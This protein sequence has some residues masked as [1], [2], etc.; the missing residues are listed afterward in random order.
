MIKKYI[1]TLLVLFLFP[2]S[3]VLAMTASSGENVF[4]GGMPIEGN[5]FL[6]GNSVTIDNEVKG[7]AFAFGEKIYVNGK[8]DG[9]LICAAKEVIVNGEVNGNIRCAFQTLKVNGKVE[10][11]V[12]GLGEDMA[13]E[14]N[15]SVGRDLMFAGESADVD[16]VVNGSMDVASSVLNINGNVKQNVNFYSEEKDSKTTGLFVNSGSSINGNV[17][18]NAFGEIKG[19]GSGSILGATNKYTPKIENKDI[20]SDI[21]SQ[22]GFIVALILTTLAIVIIGGKSVENIEKK[23]TGSIWK[24]VG[25]GAISFFALPIIGIALM[26]SGFGAFL[27]I[28]CFL[29]WLTILLLALFFAGISLGELLIRKIGKK[30]KSK[31]ILNSLIGVLIGYVLIIIPILGFILFFFGLWWGI[32]GVILA[33]A[34]KRKEISE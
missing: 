6:T 14:K 27:G 1:L 18:Y 30:E 32:G 21:L 11:S 25:I 17:N 13:I 2:I 31:F 15:G 22:V 7:D 34:K 12:L 20:K 8:I 16:G 10:R 26:V 5:A 4:V 24:A 29:I 23:M 19:T 33:F 3:A 28:V 9:D